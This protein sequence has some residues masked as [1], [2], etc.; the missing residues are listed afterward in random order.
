[1]LNI[2]NMILN[3]C[4]I[5]KTRKQKT[6]FIDIIRLAC[7]EEE[8]PVCVEQGGLL[9]S[10]NIIIGNVDTAKLIVGAHYDTPLELVFPNY[11]IPNSRLVRL[12]Y[13]LTTSIITILL[14][15]GILPIIVY[16]T[17]RN[18]NY[19]LWLFIF[20]D[21]LFVICL[22][23]GIGRANRHNTN[24]NTSGVITLLEIIFSKS[25]I[26]FNNVSFVFFDNEEKGLIG[27][28]IFKKMHKKQ[29][30]ANLLINFDCVAEGDTFL[31]AQNKLLFQDVL[32]KSYKD[33]GEK[34]FVFSNAKKSHIASDQR[35]YPN[36]VGITALKKSKLGL[37]MDKIHTYRDNAF[38]ESNIKILR[39]CTLSLISELN[40]NECRKAG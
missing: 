28:S 38:D 30:E 31:V 11:L 19:S 7:E 15:C 16:L 27:S 12:L 8:I 18:L 26:D 10:R 1:M 2:S 13:H 34:N 37:Y 24:D 23:L 40:N 9:K 25:K 35:K 4:L 14:Y 29:M 20:L 3:N 33:M 21:I 5:R 6:A 32:E 17:T 36:G 39:D 22:K